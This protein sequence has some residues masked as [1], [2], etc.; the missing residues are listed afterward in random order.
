MND[1][2][3]LTIPSKKSY[4]RVARSAM[5]NF[6]ILNGSPDS[7]I[8]DMEIVLGEILA[9][10][11]QHTYKCNETKKIIISYVIRGDS[12]SI[13]V[14]DFGNPVDPAKLKPLPPDLENPREG[15]Y[16]L[17]IIHKVTDK[18]EV[19]TFNNGNLFIAEK[20]LG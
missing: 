3:V 8:V 13:L 2:I 19:K 16:G 11:I 1:F 9:N 15:G 6:L 14:R 12:F 7:V 17:Y 18:F 10:V 20:N 4:I 5:R